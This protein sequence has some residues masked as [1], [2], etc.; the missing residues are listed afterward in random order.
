MTTASTHSFIEAA[1]ALA[2]QIQAYTE[3][4][5]QARRLPLP[6][7]E[8]M[9]K[10]GLF[11]LCIP[12]QLGGVEADPMT[13]ARIIEEVSKGDGAV[14]W[15]LM[16]GGAYGMFGG[17]L[18][19]ESAREIY[20]SDPNVITAGAFRPLGQAI[21]V[22]GGYRVTGQWPLGSGCQHSSW[23]LGGCRIFDGDHPR[24]RAD[25][26]PVVRILF[27]PAEDC[28]IIDTWHAAGLRGTGSHDYAVSDLF[29]PGTRS[30]SFR[31]PPVQPG[32]LYA[33]PT[34]AIFSTWIAAVPLG[35][36]RHAIDTLVELAGVKTATRSQ[37]PLRQHATV[38]TDLA[39]AEALL[40]SGRAFLYETL[41]ET[42]QVVTTGDTLSLEQ[43]S[44]L[45]LA[46]TQATVAATQAVELMFSAGGSS[47]VY[48]SSPL[49]RCL[50]D[51]RTA[52]QHM[53][54]VPSN[55][56]MVGQALLGFDM[57]QTPLLRV[58][59]RGEG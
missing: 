40:R 3:E 47:S 16:I 50:R 11:R 56:E 46:A 39:R 41:E 54:V 30:F 6:L 42:W 49:E 32:P 38:Q 1:R 29:V 59:D 13:F 23:L 19:D 43:R 51:I 20:G 24:L 14:G 48:T 9:A 44:M 26:T 10:A 2:P 33:L 25:G 34:I 28:E 5:E 57:S 58:D 17:Y 52:G 22:D 45:W 15:C 12:Q 36:A 8:S 18:P 21:V 7:V 4:I 53:V 35:I 37:N 31:E 27:F 55:Y